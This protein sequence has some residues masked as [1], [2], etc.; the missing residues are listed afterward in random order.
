[1]ARVLV[2]DDNSS[3]RRVISYTLRKCGYEVITAADAFEGQEQLAAPPGIDLMIL[4]VAMPKLDGL[5]LLKQLRA[6][7]RYKQLP[8]IML[9]AS[10]DDQ[11]H[12]TA[13]AEG[14]NEFLTKPASSHLLI[15]TVGRLLSM[16]T[17]RAC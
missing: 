11:D 14:A 12:L 13:R 8:V 16:Q 7:E 15:E 3:V 6:D 4:D 1:M 17:T 2:I 9:T 10:C 5:T